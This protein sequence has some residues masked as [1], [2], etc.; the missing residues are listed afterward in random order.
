M[1][2]KTAKRRQGDAFE[3]QAVQMLVAAGLKIIAQNYLVAKVGE[4]DII[5]IADKT[6][7]GRC[8]RELVFVE[9][10]SRMRSEF[11]TAIDSINHAK[12][13]K[14]RRTAEHFLQAY[15]QFADLSIRFDVMAF[16]IAQDGAITH[17]WIVSA[18]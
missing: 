11:G 17:E 9:V 18:F 1:T 2:T 5:A 3:T 4:I 13:Q 12:V 8:V 14:I 6:V 10:R 15:P 7:R 16:D